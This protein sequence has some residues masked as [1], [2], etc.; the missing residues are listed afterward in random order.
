MNTQQ[1]Q[2]AQSAQHQQWLLELTNLPTAAGRE[3]RVIAWIHQWAAQREAWLHISADDFG[4][5]T[6]RHKGVDSPTPLF[7]TAH[8]DHPAFVVE[9]VIDHRRIE[10]AFRGGVGEGY[11]LNTAVRLHHGDCPPQQGRITAFTAAQ[12]PHGDPRV[13]VTFNHDI[14]AQVGDVLTWDVGDS[15]IEGDLLHAPACDD[16]AGVAAALSAFDAVMENGHKSPGKPDLRLLLTRA[17]EI[18]FVGA[19]AACQSGQLPAKG[20]YILL[21]NSRSFADS[22]IAG[23][24]IVRVGDRAS[25]FDPDLIYRLGRVAQQIQEADP[26]FKWQRKLMPG[27]TCEASAYQAFGLTAA[28]LCLP[29]GNYHNMNDAAKPPAPPQIAAEIISLADY[30]G[31]IRLLTQVAVALDDPAATPSLRSR[32]EAILQARRAILDEG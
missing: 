26:S 27:G 20:R 29:L 7:I 10:A 32:L 15:R 11:F 6:L 22:P 9:R 1:I 24:P 21:E 2:H 23:G 25:T 3:S 8:M 18:G 30:H 28:C 13:T 12:G 16:L 17:E 31:L 19:I 4:N 5:L 14:T